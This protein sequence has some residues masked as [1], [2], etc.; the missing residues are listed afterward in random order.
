[1]IRLFSALTLGLAM[2]FSTGM[3][4]AQTPPP[5]PGQN[6][7]PIVFKGS[8]DLDSFGRLAFTIRGTEVVMLDSTDVPVKGTA[9][10]VGTRHTFT[11]ANCVYEGELVNGVIAGTA[12]FTSGN[13]EGKS[14]TYNVRL[15][16]N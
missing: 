15:N 5:N 6:S 2:L 11:F 8:E 10:I 3:A 16:S 12:R 13:D 14:W 4:S 7:A 9:T 1:M